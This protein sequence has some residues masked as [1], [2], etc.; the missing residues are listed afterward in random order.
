MSCYMPYAEHTDSNNDKPIAEGDRSTKSSAYMRLLI[1]VVP[2]VQPT[3]NYIWV[4]VR[5]SDILAN[6]F[7]P[8]SY[9][10]HLS[11]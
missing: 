3:L 2:I 4:I 9:R 5:K 1:N 6:I 10:S 11:M 7:V 8:A